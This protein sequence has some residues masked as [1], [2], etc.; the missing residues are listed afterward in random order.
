MFSNELPLVNHMRAAG[1]T[2]LDLIPALK[3]QVALSGMGMSFS[4]NRLL[5]GRL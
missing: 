2:L 3:T 1:L 5:R 4:G